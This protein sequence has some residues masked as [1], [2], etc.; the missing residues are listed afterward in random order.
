[1]DML[2]VTHSWAVVG[3]HFELYYFD[4]S[5]QTAALYGTVTISYR[6]P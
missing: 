1:M 2:I 5:I 3:L 4:F 6:Q